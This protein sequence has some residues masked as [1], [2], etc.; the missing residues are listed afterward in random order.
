[1]TAFGI[2]A[3]FLSVLGVGIPIM[4]V[5]LSGLSGLFSLFASKKLDPLANA[6]LIINLLNLTVLSPHTVG[7][8]FNPTPSLFAMGDGTMVVYIIC[9]LIQLIGF[10]LWRLNYVRKI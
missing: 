7:A 9:V 6:A 2:V 8:I 3:I 4:G 5:L 10:A 1:M